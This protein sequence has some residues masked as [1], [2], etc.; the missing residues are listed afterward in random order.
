M[1]SSQE[2]GVGRNASLPCTTKRRITTNLTTQNKQN[3]QKIKLHGTLTKKELKK[4]SPRPLGEAETGSWAE[5]NCSKAKD[6]M[7]QV[8]LADK[9]TTDSK[10]LPVKSCGVTKDLSL[11]HI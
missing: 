5:R 1:N 7:G 6:G 4:Y 2:E 10:P 3:C 9:E 11:I 8:G